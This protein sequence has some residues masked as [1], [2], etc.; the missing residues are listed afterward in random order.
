V[1]EAPTERNALL[2]DVIVDPL[3]GVVIDGGVQAAGL[4]VTV[5]PALSAGVPHWPVTLT[6]YVVVADGVTLIDEFVPPEAGEDVLEGVPM[7]HW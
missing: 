2:P 5:A 7:Y 3:G 1:P 4:T 6:Q